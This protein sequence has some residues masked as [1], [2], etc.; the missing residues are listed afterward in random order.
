MTRV[1]D[2]NYKAQRGRRRG[3]YVI[4]VAFASYCCAR[5][6]VCFPENLGSLLLPSHLARLLRPQSPQDWKKAKEEEKENIERIRVDTGRMIHGTESLTFFLV[7]HAPLARSFLPCYFCF[8]RGKSG[9]PV[10]HLYFLCRLLKKRTGEFWITSS[11]FYV[12]FPL[13]LCSLWL[14]TCTCCLKRVHMQS[15]FAALEG[16]KGSL[17]GL[18]CYIG[19]LKFFFFFFKLMG[20][21]PTNFPFFTSHI[22]CPSN[23]GRK[24]VVGWGG[25]LVNLY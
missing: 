18:M 16:K 5:Q 6:P 11:S 13:F 7:F 10:G 24:W 3:I 2:S 19:L 4:P 1:T 25:A 15:I 9:W 17:R 8:S 22:L 14:R 20:H 23:L 21:S 12:L